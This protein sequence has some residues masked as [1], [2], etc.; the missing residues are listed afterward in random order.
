MKVVLLVAAAVLLT[1]VVALTL[2]F[3]VSRRLTGN[4]LGLLRQLY[5]EGNEEEHR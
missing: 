2:L 5:R 1:L 4:L 3:L